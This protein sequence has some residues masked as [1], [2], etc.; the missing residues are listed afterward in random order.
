[1]EVDKQNRFI[2]GFYTFRGKAPS[3][4]LHSKVRAQNRRGYQKSD[5]SPSRPWRKRTSKSH[6]TS[7]LELNMFCAKSRLFPGEAIFLVLV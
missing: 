7:K 2:Y 5:L 1:M 3:C 6:I 4:F